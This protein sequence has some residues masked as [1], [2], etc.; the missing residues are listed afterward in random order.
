MSTTQPSAKWLSLMSCPADNLIIP[1]GIHGNNYI[2]MD[3]TNAINCM[4][5]YDIDSDKWN[6]LNGFN[7]LENISIWSTALN[8]QKQTLF[9]FRLNYITE[10]QLNN[11]NINNSNH[12]LLSDTESQSIIINNSLFIVGG[13]KNNNS[14]TKWD[15]QT[16]TLTKFSNMYNNINIGLFGMIYNHINNTIL[17]FGGYDNNNNVHFNHI[18]EFNIETKQWNKLPISL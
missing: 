9:L 15:S 13:G 6:K 5:K 17:F 2:I 4:Y 7:N 1:N 14:I 18:L 12:N 11:N 3:S 8:T 10:I 16:K